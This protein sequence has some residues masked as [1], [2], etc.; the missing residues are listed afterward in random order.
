MSLTDNLKEFKKMFAGIGIEPNPEVPVK[1]QSGGLDGVF[2]V[3]QAKAIT[4]YVHRR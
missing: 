4:D 2:N 3:T 1:I